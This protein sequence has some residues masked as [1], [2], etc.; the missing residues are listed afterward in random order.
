MVHNCTIEI[1]RLKITFKHDELKPIDFYHLNETE[2][3]SR[4][5]YTSY[6]DLNKKK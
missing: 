5:L 4:I 3:L 6:L 2:V 1:C